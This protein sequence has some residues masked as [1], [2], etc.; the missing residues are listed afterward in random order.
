MSRSFKTEV[1]FKRNR[2][3]VIKSAVKAVRED[4]TYYIEQGVQE[5]EAQRL[6]NADSR[7][8]HYNGV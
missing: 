2:R 3:T 6:G 7:H 8:I 4:R 5:Y 1:K